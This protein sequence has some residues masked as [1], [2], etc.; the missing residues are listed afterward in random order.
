MQS[1]MNVSKE[2]KKSSSKMKTSVIIKHS[3][4]IDMSKEKFDAC[5]K[6][7]DTEQRIVIKGS[8][9]FNNTASGFKLFTEWCSKRK[10]EGIRQVFTME[11]TGVYYESLAFYLY[12]HDLY[13]SV[14]LPNR[15][16]N[17]FKGL[18]IKSKTDKID[19]A[20]LAQMGAE[21]N[22]P[23]WNRPDDW[24]VS[25]RQ[26]TRQREQ[27]QETRTTLL[28][29]KEAL[30]HNGLVNDKLIKNLNSI[31]ETINES[32]MF[33]SKEVDKIL[34][35]DPSRKEKINKICRIKGVAQLTVAIVLAET[36][37]F[38]DFNSS[39]QLVSYAGYDVVENQS[40]KH[41]GPTRISKR[42]NA[43]IRRAMH[44]PALN[45][46]SAD[47]DPVLVGLWERVYDRTKRKMKAYVAVQRKLL[48]L[49]Y[50]LWKNDVEYIPGYKKKPCTEAGLS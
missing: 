34:D 44:L 24:T 43:H 38:K 39:S 2:V 31:L 32:L 37:C 25:L 11:A 12:D 36:N 18:G 22:L 26:T 29:Q 4:G 46:K 6:T 35:A 48:L 3:I 15:S 19:A 47:E 20:A 27:L 7:Y 21:Q 8:R 45:V 13:V 28:N 1:R 42:G 9:S 49:I 30:M 14:V 41:S 17:Y 16:K 33:L 50:T 40:G 5:Y 10:V 23:L